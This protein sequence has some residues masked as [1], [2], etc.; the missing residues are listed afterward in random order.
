[1]PGPIHSATGPDESPSLRSFTMRHGWLAPWTYNRGALDRQ[2]ESSPH[3]RLEI[4][5]ALV[6]LGRL[7]SR[8]R[9]VELRMRAVLRGVV[10]TDLIIGAAVCRA[11]V[12][13]FELVVVQAKR[14]AYEAPRSC[15]SCGERAAGQF[16]FD[17]AIV[18]CV[19]ANDCVR[20]SVR[21]L[22]ILDDPH[23]RFPE[24]GDGFQLH[25]VGNQLINCL[26][27]QC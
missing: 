25:L 15:G 11:Q 19:A 4:D 9:E 24:I 14:Y 23:G 17:L 21:N 6:F 20:L 1:M 7:A 2:A 16:D 3:A 13:V 5:I 27:R 12:D 26:C 10:A 18:K 8:D 22:A